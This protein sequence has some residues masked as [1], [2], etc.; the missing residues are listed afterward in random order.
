MPGK[1][2]SSLSYSLCPQLS[3][4]RRCHCASRASCP[5]REGLCTLGGCSGPPY[6]LHSPFPYMGTARVAGTAWGT[7]Q[8]PCA[9]T[10]SPGT[11]S[12]GLRRQALQF[13]GPD[14]SNNRRRGPE[15]T[16]GHCQG[17]EPQKVVFS[18]ERKK[19]LVNINYISWRKNACFPHVYLFISPGAP[20]STG[21]G[22]PPPPCAPTLC[23]DDPGQLLCPSCLGNKCPLQREIALTSSGALMFRFTLPLVMLWGVIC[24]LV[25]GF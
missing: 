6:C 16:Q 14:P 21:V 11:A 19:N 12:E 7:G 23:Q 2:R 25:L 3:S 5:K 13:P 15:D 8:A 20:S 24:S 10:P 18:L 9:S 1:E 17:L 4:V 22:A